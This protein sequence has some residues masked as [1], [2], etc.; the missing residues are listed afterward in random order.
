[1]TPRPAPLVAVAA[2]TLLLAACGSSGGD[3][4]TTSGS[5]TTTTTTS[6]DGAAGQAEA[7][8]EAYEFDPASPPGETRA[9][10][11]LELEKVEAQANGARGPVTFT[12]SDGPVR[13]TGNSKPGWHTIDRT[14][15]KPAS[16]T[17]RTYPG[18]TRQ[19]ID[20][21]EPGAPT[22]T[23]N[24]DG[25]ID[26]VY[27]DGTRTH[28]GGN[29]YSETAPD[30][31]GPMGPGDTF[32]SYDSDGTH[33][34][35]GPDGDYLE[36][37]DGTRHYWD[38]DGN[39]DLAIPPPVTL[40]PP[41]PGK[42]PSG[43]VGEPHYLTEDGVS[44]TTQ[45]L[46]EFVLST[47]VAGQE[48]QA[49]TQPWDRSPV[50]A[51]ITALAFGVDDQRVTV[52]LDGT[53]RVD[54][55][56][57]PEG[58]ELQ[59]GFDD[60]GAV[61]LWRADGDE[62]GP[63]VAVVVIWPD[64]STTWVSFHETW[65]D[66]RVQWREATGNR[67]GL[68]GS[69]DG[70]PSNDR[71][72]RDGTQVE[73]AGV[74]D[75]AASWYVTADE[76]LFDYQDGLGTEDYRDDGFPYEQQS[77]DLSAGEAACA[78][79]P[80]GFARDACS[81]DVGLTGVKVWVEPALAFGRAA[82]A[83]EFARGAVEAMGA[84]ISALGSSTGSGGET[85]GSQEL[86]ELALT[87]ADRAGA[88]AVDPEGQVA[89]ELGTGE[90]ATY[91]FELAEAAEAYALNDNLDCPNQAF[92]PGAGGFATFDSEG[93]LVSGPAPACDDS[94]HVDLAAGTYFLKLVGPGT[95]SLNLETLPAN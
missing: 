79:V 93:A 42:A 3:T 49:R 24:A 13:L 53:V 35:L 47:G 40:P 51:A 36:D 9:P 57:A 16:G 83:D 12:P 69:D 78:E 21:D 27:P 88:E 18:G 71:S 52:D 92:E 82:A 89:T 64:L 17:H 5:T 38:E 45:R 32:D 46:G 74:E 59:F 8:A 20:L 6:A 50:A 80:D 39:E 23:W 84:R 26:Q 4:R 29:G 48:I 54:G 87:D 70:D 91:R 62:T 15:T 60:G 28:L 33:I 37:P 95:F 66:L 34:H 72:L 30:D 7:G 76:S 14:P 94:E 86:G 25:T 68:L 22:T 19:E 65:L 77:P 10:V 90:S 31:D 56:E 67:R 43:G 58:A 44:I 55:Q 81:Y 11:I 1:M 63:A 61:G 41:P 73:E 85:G 2:A 75:L